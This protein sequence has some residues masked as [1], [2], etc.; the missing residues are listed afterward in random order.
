MQ[1]KVKKI[2]KQIPFMNFIIKQKNLCKE[3]KYKKMKEED[4]EDNLKKWYKKETG[5]LLD[6]KNP[7]SFNEKI[8][9]L[10]LYDSTPLK[11]QLADKYL[12]REWVSE[13]I[14]EEYLIPLLGVWDNAN[15]ISFETLPDEFILKTNHG[16]GWNL[17]IKDR[18]NINE[19]KIKKT[20]N[21]WLSYNYGYKKGM[22]LHYRA[23]EPKIMAETLVR[24]FTEEEGLRDYGFFC[25]SGEI[26]F[27]TS[28]IPHEGLWKKGTYTLE[29]EKAPFSIGK[30]YIEEEEKEPK[31]FK[32]MCQLAKTLSEGFS[33]VRVDLYNINGKILFGEMTFTPASGINKLIPREWEKTIGGWINL[34]N[35]KSDKS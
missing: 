27:I 11:T 18:K 10:K 35:K 19:K 29:W 8:Q 16:S 1:K 28:N 22:E 32:L 5:D 2:I 4:Y 33:F 3:N 26:K 17:L 15:E 12:V 30:Y 25:F 13:K 24:E 34:T 23:I 21:N 6:L 9:W 20:L 7:L 31:N 14:G